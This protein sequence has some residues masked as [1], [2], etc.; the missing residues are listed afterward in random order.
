VLS[1][2]P[3]RNKLILTHKKSLVKSES[4]AVTTYEDCKEGRVIE[5]FIADIKQ[6]GVVV[7]F[8]NNVKVSRYSR[9]RLSSLYGIIYS[10]E[11]AM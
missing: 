11:S 1:V 4:H 6:A 7:V 8:Y 2:D 10:A 3:S 5:G 9:L